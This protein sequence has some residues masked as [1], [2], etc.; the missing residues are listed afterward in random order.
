[1][2]NI[3]KRGIGVLL[4]LTLLLGVLPASSK[5]VQAEEETANQLEVYQE[6][7]SIGSS[8]GFKK[9]KVVK[10]YVG[11]NYAPKIKWE[12]GEK[13]Q[14]GT[15]SDLKNSVFK[16]ENKKIA[17][18]NEKGIVTA[19][20]PGKTEIQ[21]TSDEWS[22][23]IKIKVLAIKKI[24]KNK[25]V[26]TIKADESCWNMPLT[27][28]YDKKEEAVKKG[29]VKAN[30]KYDLLLDSVSIYKQ[31]N[32]SK[33]YM[34]NYAVYDEKGKQ[35][36]NVKSVQVPYE[37]VLVY[38]H[39][40]EVDFSTWVFVNCC[41]GKTFGISGEFNGIESKKDLRNPP[42]TKKDMGEFTWWE[43]GWKNLCG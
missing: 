25:L 20:K 2:K 7:P 5:I 26:K 39:I 27:V 28:T 17:S 33:R 19:K 12:S 37:K 31:P 35:I 16:S 34:L 3:V 15:V 9:G 32:N 40:C 36:K 24:K 30:K 41:K 4:A 43:Y 8:G 38:L 22:G 10:L 1:M 11:M 29:Y 18:I 14:Y 42:K 23:T 13:V 6:Y 21:V